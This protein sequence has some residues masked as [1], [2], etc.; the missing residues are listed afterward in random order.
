M[1]YLMLNETKQQEEITEFFCLTYPHLI[2]IITV[3]TQALS[4]LQQS[5]FHLSFQCWT[6]FSIHVVS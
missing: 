4:K 2:N 6:V 3:F 5:A 1:S